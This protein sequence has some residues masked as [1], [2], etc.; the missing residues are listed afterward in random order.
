MAGLLK[1]FVDVESGWLM[2]S[3]RVRSPLNPSQLPPFVQSDVVPVELY[4]YDHNQAGGL[5]DQVHLITS[6]VYTVKVAIVTPSPT[7]PVTHAQVTLTA[8]ASIDSTG[9]YTG[10]LALGAAITAL[11]A[12]ATSISST[13]TIQILN[14]SDIRTP[15][16]MPCSVKAQGITTGVPDSVPGVTFPSWPE[17]NATFVKRVGL[18][19][20]SFKL[21]SPDGSKS[22]LI[23]WGDDNSLHAEAIT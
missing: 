9:K 11:L 20:E 4:L 19:G 1:L 18:A 8:D 23:Y 7:A 16:M 12:A 10:S 5:Q 2:V 3:S 21:V 6:P 15:V 22:G 17:A 14:G 13:F